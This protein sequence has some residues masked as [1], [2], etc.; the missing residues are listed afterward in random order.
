MDSEGINMSEEYLNHLREIAV[1]ADSIADFLERYYRKRRYRRHGDEDGAKL[2]T[3]YQKEF[4][5]FG[6]VLTSRHDNITGEMI[7]WLGPE[8]EH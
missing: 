2:R 5:K 7:A 3:A 4:E 1:E 6:Y 8:K